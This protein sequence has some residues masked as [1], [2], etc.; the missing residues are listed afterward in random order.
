MKSRL[1]DFSASLFDTRPFFLYFSSTI[2][3]LAITSLVTE[4]KS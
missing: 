4:H 2:M 1:E 3:L